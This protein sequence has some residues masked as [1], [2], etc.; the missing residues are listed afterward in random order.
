MDSHKV[1]F[2][3]WVDIAPTSLKYGQVLDLWKAV[4]DNRQEWRR[5]VCTVSE[6]YDVKGR[7]RRKTQRVEKK[8]QVMTL[9]CSRTVLCYIHFCL[10]Y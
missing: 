5:L 9:N 2:L 10:G 7:N 1:L 6:S 8:R 3:T 4:V